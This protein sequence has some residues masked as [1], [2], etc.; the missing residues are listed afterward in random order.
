M[1]KAL[2]VGHVLVSRSIRSIGVKPLVS[3][4]HVGGRGGRVH[5]LVGGG[6]RFRVLVGGLHG[7][8]SDVGDVAGDGLGVGLSVGDDNN[9]KRFGSLFIGCCGSRGEL[10]VI[11]SST[12]DDG[13]T[14]LLIVGV[15]SRRH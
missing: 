1:G 13:R 15:V 7:A 8:I 9:C 3:G 5:V 11:T 10:G 12:N 6:G 4:F 14:T 2:R